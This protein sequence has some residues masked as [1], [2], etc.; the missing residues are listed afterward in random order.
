ME[1][2]I[3]EVVKEKYTEVVK[4]SQSCCEPS[5]CSPGGIDFSEG[6][7]KLEGYNKDAD[8][9]LGCGLPTEFARIQE[10]QT[11]LD[12][13]AGAGNDVVRLSIGIEAVEDIIADIDQALAKA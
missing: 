1:K 4:S 3:K 7:E 5:C 6:Y 8:L 2:A 11:V 9:G 12:L 13:G 10:G